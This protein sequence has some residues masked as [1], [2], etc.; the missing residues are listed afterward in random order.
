MDV[1]P[2]NPNIIPAPVTGKIV[3]GNIVPLDYQ[4]QASGKCNYMNIILWI[5][6][7][8]LGA[9]IVHKMFLKPKYSTILQLQTAANEY[10]ATDVEKMFAAGAG[11]ICLFVYADWCG[12]CKSC[13]A[14][15]NELATTTDVTIAKFNGGG[16]SSQA[17][18]QF[19]AEKGFN[20][21]GF[22]FFLCLENGV[23][24]AQQ[25]G[26]FQRNEDGS[27]LS[28]MQTFANGAFQ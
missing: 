4:P 9:V 14:D 1:N 2:Q 15:Y 19:L 12:H 25:T 26:A 3:D 10:T 24:K 23:E 22:P 16:E 18:I 28:N 13:K 17:T 6:V 27:M 5:I 20:I 8:I 7:G 21:Q 11:K